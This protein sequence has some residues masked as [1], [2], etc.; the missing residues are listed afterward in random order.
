ME[1]CYPVERSQPF[2][3]EK[4]NFAPMPENNLKI[5][6]PVKYFCQ[7][8]TN[9]LYARFIVPAKPEG[10]KSKVGQLVKPRII[11]ITDCFLRNLRVY[12]QRNAKRFSTL[13][14]FP[15]IFMV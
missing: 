3:V 9:K 6:K 1:F 4:N 11:K 5:G 10:R 7:N 2:S 14:H 8:Q 15:E 12:K 13:K